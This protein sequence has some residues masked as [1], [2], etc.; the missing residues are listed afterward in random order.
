M[1]AKENTDLNNKDKDV[2]EQRIMVQT[3]GTTFEDTCHSLF[4][5]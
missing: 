1:K 5:F 4:L 2:K 3:C